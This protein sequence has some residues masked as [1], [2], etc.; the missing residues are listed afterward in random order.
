MHQQRERIA[1]EQDNL[2]NKRREIFI[3]VEKGPER[4]PPTAG[5]PSRWSTFPTAIFWPFGTDVSL[6]TSVMTSV[7]T[8]ARLMS[9]PDHY[10]DQVFD[11]FKLPIM[12]L[13]WILHGSVLLG[14]DRPNKIPN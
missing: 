4:S 2:I 6:L 10:S 13:K 3:Q 8:S 11:P 12:D 14:L 5:L 1:Q 7:M 9:L